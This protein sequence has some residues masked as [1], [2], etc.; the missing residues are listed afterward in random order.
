MNKILMDKKF[1][2]PEE[3]LR[4]ITMSLHNYSDGGDGV[5]RAKF[6]KNNKYCTYQML[7]GLKHFFDNPESINSRQQ[8]DLAG[9][10]IMKNWVELTLRTQRASVQQDGKKEIKS[11]KDNVSSLRPQKISTDLS[12]NEEEDKEMKCVICILF[13]SN[14]EILMLKRSKTD[15]W[16]PEKWSF[17]GGTIEDDESAITAAK[18]EIKEEINITIT[19]LVEKLSIKREIQDEFIFIGMISESSE[20]EIKLDEENDD[21]KFVSVDKITSLDCVPNVMDYIRIVLGNSEYISK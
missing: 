4:N 14:N 11:T 3:I 8:Y 17:L 19:K 2:V 15:N 18:R 5:K 1:P 7:K 10:D 12:L 16:M 9:G 21:Y 13:N 20:K 6:I